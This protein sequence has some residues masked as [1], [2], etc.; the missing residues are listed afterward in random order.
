MEILHSLLAKSG[1]LELNQVQIERGTSDLS[2]RKRWAALPDK[3]A[4][5]AHLARPPFYLGVT[6]P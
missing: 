6:E 5:G 3:F 4:A 1:K 2:S